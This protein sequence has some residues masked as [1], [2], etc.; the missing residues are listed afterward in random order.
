MQTVSS[1]CLLLCHSVFFFFLFSLLRSIYSFAYGFNLAIHFSK[2]DARVHDRSYIAHDVRVFTSWNSVHAKSNMKKK[3]HVKLIRRRRRR[4]SALK[5]LKHKEKSM[6]IVTY[7]MFVLDSID[8]FFALQFLILVFL[9]IF[10]Y[11][12]LRF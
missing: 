11:W 6:L 10:I 7:R 9:F 2:S 8:R 1:L 12:C 4:R 5:G 3:K